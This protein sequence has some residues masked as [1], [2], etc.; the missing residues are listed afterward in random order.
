MDE[1]KSDARKTRGEASSGIRSI[2][3]K[4]A[5][6]L[7]GRAGRELSFGAG[8]DFAMDLGCWGILTK[9]PLGTLIEP[10]G[11]GRDESSRDSFHSS[12]K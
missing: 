3:A 6:Q 10:V 8:E 1:R 4:W 5:L 11:F 9:P 2:K 7:N 12:I